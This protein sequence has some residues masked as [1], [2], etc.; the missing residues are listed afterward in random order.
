MAQDVV[1]LT[2]VTIASCKVIMCP[3]IHLPKE[4]EVTLIPGAINQGKK[5]KERKKERN[6][7]FLQQILVDFRWLIHV[8]EFSRATER[9][10]AKPK[11]KKKWN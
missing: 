8:M 7:C 10:N 5:K 9:V 3:I 4:T 6:K 1:F 11:R 2:F